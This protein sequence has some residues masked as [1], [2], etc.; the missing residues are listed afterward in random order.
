MQPEAVCWRLALPHL[1]TGS[2]YV[3]AVLGVWLCWRTALAATAWAKGTKQPLITR[4]RFGLKR[5]FSPLFAQSRPR[6]I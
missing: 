3:V 4:L 6:L 2:G 5:L 1:P